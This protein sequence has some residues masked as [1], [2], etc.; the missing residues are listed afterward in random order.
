[1]TPPFADVSDLDLNENMEFAFLRQACRLAISSLHV[2]AVA[3]SAAF[4]SRATLHLENLALRRQLSV[5]RRSVK[6]PKL[7]SA[8]PLLWAWLCEAW[9]DWRSALV[10][11]KPET[12]I[13]WHRKGF[14]LPVL[15]LNRLSCRRDHRS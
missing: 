5:L 6:R 12:V 3:A 13:S 14:R 4:K 1:M 2:L 15:A 9:S 8:D 11:V 10:I 7:T